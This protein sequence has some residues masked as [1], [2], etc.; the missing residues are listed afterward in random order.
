MRFRTFIL[1]LHCACSS[2]DPL[3]HILHC[4]VPIFWILMA[5]NGVIWERGNDPLV[6]NKYTSDATIMPLMSSE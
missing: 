2:I 5:P 6:L 3:T 1:T 4:E